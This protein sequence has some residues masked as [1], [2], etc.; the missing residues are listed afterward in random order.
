MDFP[1]PH[2]N[3]QMSSFMKLE[4]NFLYVRKIKKTS[5]GMLNEWQWVNGGL[6]SHK[7]L[8]SFVQQDDT[9]WSKKKLSF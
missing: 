7:I 5:K 3:I 9:V 4:I 6:Q 1:M 2:K 8:V